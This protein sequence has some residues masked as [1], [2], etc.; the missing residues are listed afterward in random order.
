MAK[1]SQFYRLLSLFVSSLP[2]SLSPSLGSIP[3]G[4]ASG[5]A[6]C[7]LMLPYAIGHTDAG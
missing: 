3:Q 4:V 6:A 2:L 1:G 7:N 5:Q